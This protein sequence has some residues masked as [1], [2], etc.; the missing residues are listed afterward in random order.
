ML[1]EITI[2]DEGIKRI[3]ETLAKGLSKYDLHET[4][5]AIKAGAQLVQATW[6]QYISGATV[7]YSKGDFRIN[8]NTGTYRSAVENGLVYPL[9]G[10]ILSGGV[11]VRLEYAER[12]EK[13]FD[14]YDMKDGLLNSSKAKR[15]K[16]DDPGDQG[17]P[18][19]D[20][21][22][23]HN[24][25]SIP[26]A[27]KTQVKNLG[28]ALGTV[29]LGKGL[30][31][32]PLG[33]RTKL[34]STALSPSGGPLMTKSYEWNSGLFA[35]LKKSAGGGGEHVTFRRISWNSDPNS[36][37]HPGAEPKPVTAALKE[38]L[39]PTLKKMVRAAFQQDVLN[40]ARRAGIA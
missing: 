17:S 6:M 4:R 30:E 14:P 25:G 31:K 13:G 21:P 12:L 11:I 38:N 35:G 10:D 9:G 15:T 27:I 1:A 7:S 28:R 36:W 19:I 40:F 32:A 22:F 5:A 39:G 26:R 23:R 29:R 20:I 34:R 24:V 3:K 8:S 2:N 37:I 33:I 18:Y 16:T